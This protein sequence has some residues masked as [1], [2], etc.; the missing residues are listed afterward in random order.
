[1][2]TEYLTIFNEHQQPIGTAP[3]S[4]VHKHGFWHETFHCWFVSEQDN[5]RYVYVQRR[6]REKK[7]YPGLF[8]I[9]AAGHLLSTETVKDGVREVAEETGIDVA[10]EDLVSLGIIP[11]SIQNPDMIDNELAHVF[12]Y[13]TNLEWQDFRVQVEEVEGMSRV[14]VQD[15]I[16]LWRH[17]VEEIPSE[18]FKMNVDGKREAVEQSIRREDFVSHPTTYY[19][20]IIQGMKNR[21]NGL[22][23]ER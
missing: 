6:S 22:K 15:F 10:F 14:T 1:M 13:Y 16:N 5:K 3:R 18:G 2:E 8:D 11:Y 4:E 7:D 17:Q 19:E 9:T 12:L 20:A 21:R 23:S